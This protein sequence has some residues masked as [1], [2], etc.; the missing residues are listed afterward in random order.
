MKL[1]ASITPLSVFHYTNTNP[2]RIRYQLFFSLLAGVNGAALYPHASSGE[3]RVIDWKGRY[4]EDRKVVYRVHT[5]GSPAAPRRVEAAATP[6]SKLLAEAGW[7]RLGCR[8]GVLFRGCLHW[9]L[10]CSPEKFLV[11]FDTTAESFR[12]MPSPVVAQHTLPQLLEMDATLAVSLIEDTK[13][14]MKLWVLQDYDAGVWSLKRRIVLP[15]AE[16]CGVVPNDLVCIYGT[17]VRWRHAAPLCA[18]FRS[19]SH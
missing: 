15:V 10:Y 4:S 1:N 12:S 5:V 11:V 17:V 3:Y 8:P 18:P 6:R 14:M 13:T 7:F 19:V 16:I 9:L 2:R